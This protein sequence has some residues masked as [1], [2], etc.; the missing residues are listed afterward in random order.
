MIREADWVIDQG[1]G[2]APQELIDSELCEVY[3]ISWRELQET[4]WYV[5]QSWWLFQQMKIVARQDA[6]HNQSLPPGMQGVS[7]A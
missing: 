5:R 2:E 4:P 7:R 1:S 3:H 6:E